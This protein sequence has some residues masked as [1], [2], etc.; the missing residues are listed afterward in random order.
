MNVTRNNNA[1]GV[2]TYARPPAFGI[3]ESHGIYNILIFDMKFKIT[4]EPL[5]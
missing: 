2:V 4:R 1:N 3:V 5:K